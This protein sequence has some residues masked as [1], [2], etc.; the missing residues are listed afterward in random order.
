LGFDFEEEYYPTIDVVTGLPVP[1]PEEEG[2][3]TIG[4]DHVLDLSEA[5]RQYAIMALPMAPICRPDCAGLCPECG[6]NLNQGSCACRAIARDARWEA[7]REWVQRQ[8][9]EG[10]SSHDKAGHGR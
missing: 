3:F 8:G 2:I 5:I 6:Q 4:G 10:Q 7:L 9:G 1:V